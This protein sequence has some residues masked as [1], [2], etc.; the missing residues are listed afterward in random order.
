MHIVPLATQA[1]AILRDL[2]PLTG[3]GTWIFPGVRTNGEPMEREH[4]QRG[5]VTNGL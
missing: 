1:L 3:G 4:C 2:E 5:P